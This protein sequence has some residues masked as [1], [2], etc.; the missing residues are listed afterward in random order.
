MQTEKSNA[1]AEA[2]AAR[3]EMTTA[4]ARSDDTL[5]EQAETCSRVLRTQLELQAANHAAG[6]GQ[7]NSAAASNLSLA[8]AAAQAAHEQAMKTAS[9]EHAV[10]M[11]AV[12]TKLAEA[13]ATIAKERAEYDTD[14]GKLN[15]ETNSSRNRLSYMLEE[16]NAKLYTL[17]LEHDA[18]LAATAATHAHE[19]GFLQASLAAAQETINA[20]LSYYE[21]S[22]ASLR[23]RCDDEKEGAQRQHVA[24]NATLDAQHQAAVAALEARLAQGH[25][26]AARASPTSDVSLEPMR[27]QL[28]RVTDMNRVLQNKLAGHPA[29]VAPRQ[30][31]ANHQ[32]T[33][34]AGD[35]LLLTKL[36]N[37]V[38]TYYR[39]KQV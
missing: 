26:A 17:A 2:A 12:Q 23:Q 16:A 10:E 21:Q 31:P 8:Q 9:G 27:R 18:V 32:P 15:Q 37:L 14:V 11:T 25:L 5:A 7:T 38:S 39:L 3:A 13:L 29:V 34:V 20:N 22:V 19:M 33:D 35:D 6:T 24:A 4:Q 36:D 30:A 1:L 28:A